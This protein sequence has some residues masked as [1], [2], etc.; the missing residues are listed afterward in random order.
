MAHDLLL[1]AAE[2]GEAE[3]GVEQGEGVHGGVI[4]VDSGSCADV[5]AR[6]IACKCR[7]WLSRRCRAVIRVR[8]TVAGRRFLCNSGG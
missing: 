7:G 1:L 8:G 5:L 3:H 2:R 4:S 6:S